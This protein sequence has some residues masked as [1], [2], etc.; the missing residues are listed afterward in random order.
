VS[1]IGVRILRLYFKHLEGWAT[2]QYLSL[3]LERF[4]IRDSGLDEKVCS[5]L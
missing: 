3:S 5:V 1:E 2:V 4:R